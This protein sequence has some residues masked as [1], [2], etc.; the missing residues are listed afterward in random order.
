LSLHRG[1]ARIRKRGAADLFGL[2]GASGVPLEC[3]HRTRA[4]AGSA[5][6][7]GHPCAG[8]RADAADVCRRRE[9][10]RFS[11]R[12]QLVRVVLRQ[13][14]Q[15]KHPSPSHAGW[16]FHWHPFELPGAAQAIA[17]ANARSDGVVAVWSIG[18]RHVVWLRGFF[19]VAPAEQRRYV[20]WAG[21][22][23][24]TADEDPA[25]LAQVLPAALA[26]LS[27]PRA[28]P[29]AAGDTAHETQIEIGPL[30]EAAPASADSSLT[31]AAWAG[32]E[33]AVTDPHDVALPAQ[34]G[35][36]LAWL[37]P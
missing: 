22:A 35:S 21:C 33:A 3:T 16:D 23:A 12:G 18:P 5:Q 10:Q 37:P 13:A 1:A 26:R 31:R 20:G 34:L 29:F 2:G 14:W 6:G 8:G 25:G 30:R 7:G 27:L 17:Q 32:G 9:S 24:E 28:R 4:R 19:A 36:L 15:Q 11:P